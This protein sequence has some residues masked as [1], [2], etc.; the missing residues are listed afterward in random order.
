MYP[1]LSLIGNTGPIVSG[2]VM[3]LVSRYISSR[4]SNAEIAFAV[5]LRV[6][7]A[8]MTAAGGLVAALHYNTHRLYDF[9]THASISNITIAKPTKSSVVAKPKKPSLFESLV[10]LAK[11]PYML[12]IATMV[13]SY[14][15]AIEFTEIIWKSTVKQNFPIKS[16]Y[17][18]FMGQY[19]ALVGASAFAMMLIG[20]NIVKRFG[21][22]AGALATP[23]MMALCAV[24]FYG[25]II[26]GS[27][28]KVAVY[29]G[30]LQ[31][32][33][34]KATK[35]ALFDPTKEMTYIPLDKDSKT[36]GSQRIHY[37]HNYC[38]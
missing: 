12:Q 4:I 1:L 10:I 28:V 32:V 25:A 31:N 20:S 2:L 17:M 18:A 8:I 5:S 16:E 15:L 35:Y 22:S 30:L 3:S 38:C 23:V 14:G 7:T 34:S 19:S 6:L 26:S 11:D 9:E 24:P 13:I 21:W 29:V 37:S 36:K 33:L 27:S